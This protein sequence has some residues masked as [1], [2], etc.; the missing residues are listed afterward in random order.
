MKQ[1]RC[2]AGSP[3]FR[4]AQ[5]V[6]NK[7]GARVCDPQCAGNHG[8]AGKVM[9][10]TFPELLRLTEPRSEAFEPSVEVFIGAGKLKSHP[11]VPVFLMPR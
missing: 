2:R 7:T 1:S 10:G 3:R 5:R 6:C 11:A 8:G 4:T 9:S